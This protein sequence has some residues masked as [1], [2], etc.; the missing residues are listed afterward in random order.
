LKPQELVSTKPSTPDAEKMP[1]LPDSDLIIVPIRKT[2]PV[3]TNQ[4]PSPSITETKSAKPVETS[5]ESNQKPEVAVEPPTLRIIESTNENVKLLTTSSSVSESSSNLKTGSVV[6]IKQDPVSDKKPPTASKDTA[7]VKKPQV[8]V[9]NASVRSLP[10]NEIKPASGSQSPKS[11][12]VGTNAN[13]VKIKKDVAI[14][15][16]ISDSSGKAVSP[17]TPKSNASDANISNSQ[18]QLAPTSAPISL[19]SVPVGTGA[20]LTPIPMNP[21]SLKTSPTPLSQTLASTSSPMQ[22]ETSGSRDS[23]GITGTDKPP[24][25]NSCLI[26]PEIQSILPPTLTVVPSDSPRMLSLKTIATPSLSPKPSSVPVVSSAAVK[27]SGSTVFTLPM[28]DVTITSEVKPKPTISLQ[29]PSLPKLTSANT[30]IKTPT[31]PQQILLKVVPV[32]KPHP[33]TSQ[34]PT[35]AAPVEQEK[36]IP[37]ISVG[38]T[39][40]PKVPSPI[41]TAPSTSSNDKNISSAAKSSGDAPKNKPDL[42]IS[43]KSESNLVISDAKVAAPVSTIITSST[44]PTRVEPVTSMPTTALPV[45]F[46][47]TSSTG[48]KI[49]SDGKSYVILKQIDGS[50][51]CKLASGTEVPIVCTTL[52]SSSANSTIGIP[53]SSV[54]SLSS[55]GQKTMIVNI[56]QQSSIPITSTTNASSLTP[57]VS[58]ILKTVPISIGGKTLALV[59]QTLT[60]SSAASSVTIQAATNNNPPQTLAPTSQLQNQKKLVPAPPPVPVLLQQN[61]QSQ[62]MKGTPTLTIASQAT[63]QS[64]TS[65]QQVSSQPVQSSSPTPNMLVS[66]SQNAS[67]NKNFKSRPKGKQVC[68]VRII[69]SSIPFHL[70][71]FVF[72]SS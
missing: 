9:T 6:S 25:E 2:G 5:T 14:E 16:N 10:Q 15:V 8:N 19:M 58:H 34:T 44:G 37:V 13:L 35:P 56:Q 41:V 4:I 45:T 31:K 48:T 54:V 64:A 32:S 28:K 57:G 46:V 36:S 53:T 65:V 22:V 17:L 66:S 47:T 33:Q 43:S 21:D 67:T 1:A 51:T 59:P 18:S 72:L 61:T 55:S 62:P 7:Q 20:T 40:T 71:P 3:L 29:V 52:S 26:P 12:R 50:K 11:I 49:T 39:T 24:S 27:V 60:S 30:N 23:S 69:I 42:P 70:Y 38:G 63:S 68:E